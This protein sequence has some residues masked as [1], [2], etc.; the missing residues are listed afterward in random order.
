MTGADSPHLPSE[1][2]TC[3]SQNGY[4]E[5]KHRKKERHTTKEKTNAT[6]QQHARGRKLHARLGC[7]NFID[8]VTDIRGCWHNFC[9]CNSGCR[10]GQLIAWTH[11][12]CGCVVAGRVRRF[13]SNCSSTLTM[14]WSEGRSLLT[15]LAENTQMASIEGL[16]HRDLARG[17]TCTGLCRTLDA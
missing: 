4:G 13:I 1:P 17:H 10:H 3:L 14:W 7:S 6:R 15:L 16:P 11:W 5:N 2:I 8:V 12:L 9:H